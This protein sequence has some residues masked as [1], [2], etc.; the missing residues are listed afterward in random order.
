MLNANDQSQIA[1]GEA[2]TDGLVLR[3]KTVPQNAR[4][5]VAVAAATL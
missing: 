3:V 1:R 2:D 4:R 5:V